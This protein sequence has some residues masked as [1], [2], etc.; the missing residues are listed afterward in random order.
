[1]VLTRA[2]WHLAINSLAGRR[3]RSLLLVFAVA[4]ATTLVVAVAA[5][6][7]T[8]AASA[9]LLLA[10]TTGLAD[11]RVKHRYNGR[12]NES[13]VQTLAAWPEVELAVGSLET[14]AV[15]R[16]ASGG[17]VEALVVQGVEPVLHERVVS[18][19][20]RE[21]H[22][23]TG[24]GQIVLDGPV[25]EKLGIK[26][27]DRVEVSDPGET[28]E[29]LLGGAADRMLGAGV[30]RWFRGRTPT[31]KPSLTL[32]VVGILDR[33]KLQI[34]QRPLGMVA[35]SEA[36]D[37]AGGYRQIDTVDLML[38][39]GFTPE[40]VETA[41]AADLPTDAR[42]RGT[43]GATA[44]I[45]KALTGMRVMLA[46][47][48]M[49]V[50]LSAGFIITTSLTTAVT[51]RMR[52][53][54]ILRCIG[55]GRMTIAAAQVL[56]GVMLSAAGGLL[57][58][59]LGLFLAYMLYRQHSRTLIAGFQPSWFGVSL[60]V[61][62]AILAGLVG[63]LYP[64][65][66]AARVRPLRA[67]A[68]R[69]IK[70]TTKG[71]VLCLL[72][73][74]L[75]ALIQPILLVLP[76]PTQV[77]L[78]IYLTLGL[79][80][81]FTGYFL[82]TVPVTLLLTR[83]LVKPI[84]ALACIPSVVL[85]QSIR[86]T[87]YRH[88]FTAG[89]LMV[90]LAMLV[91]IWTGGRSL[92]TDWFENIRMPDGFACR[93]GTFGLVP[94]TPGEF[95]ALSSAPGITAACPTAAFPV[96]A[97]NAQFDPTDSTPNLTL[98]VSF[99]PDSFFEMATL[100]WVEGDM[101]AAAE[102]LKRGGAVLVSREYLKA[103]GLG[104]GRTVKLQTVNGPVDFEIAGVITSPG[105]DIAVQHFGIHRYYAQASVSSVFGTRADAARHFNNNQVNLVL[106]SFERAM[107]TEQI[108]RG[109]RLAV[110][111]IT[112]NSAREIRDTVR[113]VSQ[114]FLAVASVISAAT[115]LIACFGVGNL[116]VANV[117]SRRFEYGILR[118]VGSSRG[119]LGRLILAET[120]LL[121]LAACV[122][123]TAL[124]VQLALV[125][126]EFHGRLLGLEYGVQIPW[127]IVVVGG[128]VVIA[129]ALL[130][131]LVPAV[132]LVFTHPRALLATE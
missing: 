57:G 42:F 33:P 104:V 93:V 6:S 28:S 12:L 92:M 100:E 117:A 86:V 80:L 95:N 36:Q 109:V 71:V 23:V 132:R 46:L 4:L 45:R 94:L 26:V 63:A 106:L 107:H 27:G 3:G 89:A 76:I 19:R 73:G 59:P 83:V 9:Q 51:E 61:A 29:S 91:S 32:E 54:A 41:R 113:A 31:V 64:A 24:T 131:A 55:T 38:R 52:E 70:P 13:L 105:L 97:L 8:I 103:H 102:K 119:M 25:C 130:A 53:L 35:L 126:R 124:G 1:M 67:L 5:S 98:F 62:A 120:A 116:I 74:L 77:A 128:G 96:A 18:P 82:L 20:L 79:P 68:S 58:L 122:T 48:T 129:L 118:A 34:L 66:R 22:A 127:D 87:P 44:N 112:A 125:G 69:S 99:D 81:T 10:R 85:H 2:V 110:P 7:G 121:A 75:L 17:R 114:R 108:I 90:G 40:A 43:A 84:S 37:L 49:I 78:W 111:G 101:H 88:G 65:I 56:G 16:L 123:G 15:V 50:F 30:M 72:L 14:G 21:G 60:A 47:I 39:D 115:L 11:L